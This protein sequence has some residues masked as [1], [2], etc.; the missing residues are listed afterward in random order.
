MLTFIINR[1][2]KYYA[3]EKCRSEK[4]FRMSVYLEKTQLLLLKPG[5][6]A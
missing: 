4:S 2:A 6:I 1:A 3:T 5:D